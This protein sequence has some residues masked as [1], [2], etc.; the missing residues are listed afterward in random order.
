MRPKAVP[1]VVLTGSEDNVE[2]INRILREAGHPAHCRWI[3]SLDSLPEAL[4]E[5]TELLFLFQD[6]YPDALAGVADVRNNTAPKVPLLVVQADVD[7]KAISSA[8]GHGARDAVSLA[9][10]DRFTA[11][12]EREL[13]CVRLERALN[14][15][16]NSA[17]EYKQ[18]LKAFMAGA[19]DAIAVVHE[20]ILVDANAAWAE[21]FGHAS[22]N[23]MEGTPLMD[24][25]D[26]ASHNALKGAVVATLKGRWEED[27]LRV[28][29]V[30]ADGSTALLE[31]KL[32][33]TNF[34]G[35]PAVTLSMPP[36]RPDA[37]EPL[38]LV[39]AAA[40][41]DPIT[42][43]Y[44][45]RHFIDQLEQRLSS[46][47]QGGVRALA[48]LRPDKFG[49]IK[50]EVGPLASEDLLVEL[51]E[52]LRA[53]T[54][55]SDLYGRFGGT[56]FTVFL[57]RGNL[58]DVEAWADNVLAKM[59]SHIFEV[60]NHSLS[61]TCSLG[62]AEAIAD[63]GHVEALIREAEKANKRGR[64][65]GG[66][67][68]VLQETSDLDTRALRFD[69][70][71]VR[72]IKSALMENRFRLIHLPVANLSGESGS[73]YDTLLRMVDEEG[74]ELLPTDFLPAAERNN[75]LK[76]IDRWV[77]NASL[78]FARERQLDGLFVR[79][80]KESVRDE[81]L[82]AWLTQQI[83]AADVSPASVCVQVSEEDATQH[84]KQTKT[85]IGQLQK[86]G[87]RF[88]IQHFGIGRDPTQLLSHLPM[89]FLK[90]DG[91]LMQGLAS[92][93]GLQD[94]VKGYVNTARAKNITTIAERVEDA[95]T[96]AVLFQ[97]GVAYMQGQ[98][99]HEPEVVLGETTLP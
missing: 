98:Y 82:S 7:E 57:Q 40:H 39:E 17:T 10:Q 95:N 4:Q 46:R 91:S 14:D 59:A 6:D 54:Q 12:A 97:L 49:E 67:Q 62:I 44:H 1:I 22:S 41:K 21:L 83:A 81:Q 29:A 48:Y 30:R 78:S 79:L 53:L 80:S 2:A 74:N 16:L 88:A 5:H 65:R 34:E 90:I 75:L 94:K 76:T 63:T 73:Y 23:A 93:Q 51:A 36:P 31:L 8:M 47:P 85:L 50:D 24:L 19:T 37:D 89:D 32:D 84:L 26:S 70:V 96:M 55:P 43:F 87:I 77:L 20:G 15:T 11:V 58:R 27:L 99:V 42:G 71:W 18:Q 52:V 13:R 69:E 60:A 28:S 33:R 56:V 86:Q 25:F 35:E 66:N 72:R 92:N 38:Q 45:R 64:Q 61:L 68:V 9:E 3:P